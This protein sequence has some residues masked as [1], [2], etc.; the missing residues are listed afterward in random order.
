MRNSSDK[1]DNWGNIF[2]NFNVVSLIEGPYFPKTIWK[3]K[4]K[5]VFFR[6][7]ATDTFDKF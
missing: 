4:Q 1:S 2:F 7:D 5:R 6:F 3:F